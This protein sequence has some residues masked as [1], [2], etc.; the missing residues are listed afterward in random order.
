MIILGSQVIGNLFIGKLTVHHAYVIYPS[1]II[2]ST[3]FH[4]EKCPSLDYILWEGLL[5]EQ[6]F[7]TSALL[8]WWVGCLFDV[9]DC[10]MPLRKFKQHL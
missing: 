6:L 4:S 3:V 7:S 10:P 8:T 1:L 2:N 5:K 9:G